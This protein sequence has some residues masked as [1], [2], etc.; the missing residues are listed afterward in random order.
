[1]EV[2]KGLAALLCAGAFRATQHALSSAAFNGTYPGL[3]VI[4]I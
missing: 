4:D 1:M 2:K 3:P